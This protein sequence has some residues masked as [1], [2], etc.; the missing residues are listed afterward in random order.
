MAG[1]RHIIRAEL[2]MPEVAGL[3]EEAIKLW[4]PGILEWA[5][6]RAAICRALALDSGYQGGVE[7]VALGA[8]AAF[9]RAHAFPLVGRVTAKG[10]TPRAL[11]AELTKRLISGEYMKNPQLTVSVETYRSQKILVMG[12]VQQPSDNAMTPVARGSA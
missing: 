3:G 10:M 8:V 5:A 11:E 12:Q 6:E 2:I 4:R 9:A 1:R 7:G